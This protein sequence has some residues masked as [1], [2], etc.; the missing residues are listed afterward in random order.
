MLLQLSDVLR[1]DD[2][3]RTRTLIADMLGP[4][5]IVRDDEG[6]WAEMAKPADRLLV[7]AMGGSLKLVAG[8]GPAF[9]SRFQPSQNRRKPAPLLAFR[10][11]ARPRAGIGGGGAP[12]GA[13]RTAGP[14]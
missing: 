12:G 7:Q 6:T 9:A 8:A 13:P 2:L 4:I 10:R 3:E 14:S 5:T 1:S 11:F